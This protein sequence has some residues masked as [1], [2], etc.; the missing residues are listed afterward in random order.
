MWGGVSAA[1]HRT[2]STSDYPPTVAK[3]QLAG[4]YS[5]CLGYSCFLFG[6]CVGNCCCSCFIEW[7]EWLRRWAAC[8]LTVVVRVSLSFLR[9]SRIWARWRFGRW[10]IDG[11]PRFAS[12]PRRAFGTLGAGLWSS[13]GSICSVHWTFDGSKRRNPAL[14]KLGNSVTNACCCCYCLLDFMELFEQWGFRLWWCSGYLT[15]QVWCF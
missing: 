14:Y 5:Y 9:C 6:N 8:Y 10:R 2:H 15:C 11:P 13:W 4:Y 3:L 7:M 12:I 1:S